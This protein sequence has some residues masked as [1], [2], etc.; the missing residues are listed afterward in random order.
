MSSSFTDSAADATSYTQS[1]SQSRGRDAFVRVLFHRFQVH[2]RLRLLLQHSSGRGGAGNIRRT[3]TSRDPALTLPRTAKDGPDD[4]SQTR[5]REM[6]VT[7][8]ITHSGRGGAGNIRSPSRGPA[9]PSLPPSSQYEK[10]IIRQYSERDVELPHSSGRGGAGNITSSTSPLA[11]AA[12]A[13]VAKS[14]S[15]SGVRSSGRGGAGN[16]VSPTTTTDNRDIA[17]LDELERLKHHQH[18]QHQHPDGM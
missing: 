11:V 12:A 5:G 1:R 8:A 18:Y 10:D 7:P 3:S 2:F 13:D 14:R 15:R 6:N 16:M 17:M 4:Y 9:S